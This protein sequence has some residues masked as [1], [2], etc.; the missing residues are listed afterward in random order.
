MI[1]MVYSLQLN[2]KKFKKYTTRAMYLVIPITVLVGL[3][4]LISSSTKN[5]QEAATQSIFG[6]IDKQLQLIQLKKDNVFNMGGPGGGSGMVRLDSNESMNYTEND[7]AVISGLTGVQKASIISSVPVSNITHTDLFNGIKASISSL[8][9]LE[10]DYAPLFTDSD[11]TYTEGQ[12]IPIILNSND[13]IE[14]YQDW[15]GKDEVTVEIQRGMFRTQGQTGGTVTQT[16]PMESAPIKTRAITFDKQSLIGKEFTVNIGGLAELQNYSQ[17][18]TEA[19]IVFTKLTQT[20]MDAKEADR[21]EAVSPYWNYVKISTPLTYTFKVVGVVEDTQNRSTYVPESFANKLM[22]DYIQ[23]QLDARTTKTLSTD[24]LGTTFTGIDYDG[25][26]ITNNIGFGGG[27]RVAIGRFGGG[28]GGV[29]TV[30]GVASS[31]QSD[32]YVIPGLVVQTER[33]QSAGN[34]FGEQPDVIGEYTDTTVYENAARS[35]STILIKTGDVYGRIKVVEELNNNGYAYQDTTKLGV[36][37]TIKDNVNTVSVVFTGAFIAFSILIIIFTMGKFVSESRKEIGI[38]RAIGATKS[39][40]RNL[41]ITQ[42]LLYTFISYVIGLAGG[43]LLI[44]VISRPL[45]SWFD[46]VVGS[47]LRESFSVVNTIDPSTFSRIDW[48]AF[49]IYSI[50]LLVITIIISIIPAVKASN[51]SPVEAI[52]GE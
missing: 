3:S 20:E 4:L 6:T 46:S 22:Q 35:G 29:H 49:G 18:M 27:M 19:G 5:I 52:K 38:M 44:Y 23:N 41:F 30:G 36:L 12:P 39:D 21:N 1:N 37:N 25:V 8:T 26:E 40:I 50:V 10:A 13:F 2:I 32:S 43:F 48:S 15:G 7:L 17:E 28:P 45:A 11:F 16:N 9:G 14:Q 34:P 42:S 33:N 31:E 51:V 47:S 24:L